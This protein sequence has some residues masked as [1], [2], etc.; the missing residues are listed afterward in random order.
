MSGVDTLDFALIPGQ[1]IATEIASLW[2]TWGG[3]RGEWRS[4]VEEN[5]KYVYAT[6]TA[7]TTNVSNNHMHTMKQPSFQMKIG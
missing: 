4:R 7:E 5:K 6:S 3:A 1:P 2:D